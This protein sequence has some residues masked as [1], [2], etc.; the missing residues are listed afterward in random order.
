MTPFL[1]RMIVSDLEPVL[2]L[3]DASLGGPRWPRQAYQSAVEQEQAPAF[4]AMA[5]DVLAG[6]AIAELVLDICQLESIVVA[7]EF[8]RQGI[9]SE[10]LQAVI[11]WSQERGA[12]CVELEVRVGNRA[13]IALY[14][15]AG[16]V[17]E[18]LRRGYY[19]DPE[20]D[21]VLMGLTLD[22]SAKTVKKNP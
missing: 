1:R 4:V 19:R 22:S 11:A 10:L 3:A 9:G 20:E 6:F 13:A 7:G 8:R 12:Q 5:G 18:G 14:E 16:F 15:R 21:A 17:S 2:A